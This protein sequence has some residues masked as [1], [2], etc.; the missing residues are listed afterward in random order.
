MGTVML[1][2]A[3]PF[4]GKRG[5]RREAAEAEAGVSRSEWTRM[6][7][8]LAA[9]VRGM[10]ADLYAMDAMRAS[11]QESRTSLALLESSAA[12]RY[13]AGLSMQ[14]DLIEVQ[15]QRSRVTEQLDDLAAERTAMTSRLNA[16]LD[17]AADTPVRTGASGPRVVRHRAATGART[18]ARCPQPRLAMSAHR[19][20]R[21]RLAGDGERT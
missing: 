12:S 20:R 13:S 21:T 14:A 19:A 5:L 3:I 9:E 11:L 7:R 2:Q 16:M 18:A 8:Q 17:R 4:P 6:K 1:N 15:L 10:Y